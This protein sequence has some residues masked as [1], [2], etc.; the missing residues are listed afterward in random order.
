MLAVAGKIM[1][2]AVPHPLLSAAKWLRTMAANGVTMTSEH[3]YQSSMQKAL[4]GL[5]MVPAAPIRI[6]L[7]HMST[8]ADC[9]AA[10]ASPVPD[11][12]LKK[13]GIK[14][15]ADG[16]PWVGTIASTIS[17]L[18]NPTVVNAGITPGTHGEEMMNYSRAQIDAII[19]AHGGDGH[20]FAFHCNGDIAFDIVLDAFEYGLN[21]F[22]LV[23]TDHRWRVEHVG[24]ARADQFARAASLGVGI[25]MSPFQ[26]IYW[27]DILDGTLFDSEV[28][29]QW[30]RVGDAVKSGAVVS[31][32]NDG[33]VS[34]SIPLLNLKSTVTRLTPSGK[35]HGPEQKISLDDALRAQTINGAFHLKRDDEAG[36]IE[37][38]K[39]AD[40]VILDTDPYA[41]DPAHIDKIKVQG[42]W[43]AGKPVDGDA[44]LAQ[45]EAIDP[46]EHKDLH[47]VAIS[48]P[49]K[50]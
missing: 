31:F 23:G 1:A 2:E 9:G 29:A 50:C 27:G 32:H 8:E 20:Q 5:T 28:G 48:K 39:F 40:F 41:V 6:S 15:W 17:Y 13:N 33:S 49:H 34:P 43:L 44:Y 16:S 37:V 14:L 11:S 25:S 19:D 24:A 30:Q 21:K 47:A 36:S 22:N 7:Y 35:L 45:I 3:T 26:F 10:F 46:S 18:D 42:T 12:M 38:G 4:I